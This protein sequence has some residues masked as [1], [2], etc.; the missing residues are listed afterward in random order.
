MSNLFEKIT[1]LVP[2]PKRE[3]EEEYKVVWRCYSC[4]ITSE[5]G[6]FRTDK[7]WTDYGYEYDCVCDTCESSLTAEDGEGTPECEDCN[8]SYGWYC[9]QCLKTM[10][11]E[12]WKWF[13]TPDGEPDEYL[14]PECDPPEK[15]EGN[16]GSNQ[17]P[18]P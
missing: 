3:D 6:T 18:P 7:T 16:P 13:P 1:L 5:T 2:A 17:G 9:D 8:Y 14:C 4:G 11:Q 12:C 10:C 15:R